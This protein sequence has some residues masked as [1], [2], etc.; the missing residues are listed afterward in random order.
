MGATGQPGRDPARLNAVAWAATITPAIAGASRTVPVAS[1]G[2][3][4]PTSSGQDS[5]A[6]VSTRVNVMLRRPPPVKSTPSTTTPSA[7]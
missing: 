3:W 4:V 2:G 7:M 6:P 1:T 5:Q